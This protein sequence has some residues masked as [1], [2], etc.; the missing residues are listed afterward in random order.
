MSLRD[1]QI[2]AVDAVDRAQLEGTRSLLIVAPTGA[3][4]GHVIAHL[5]RRQRSLVLVHREEIVRDLARRCAPASVRTL[6][7]GD[8]DGPADA[9]VTVAL[10]QSL[11]AADVVIPGLE[12]IITDE[13][14]H[15]VASTYR[16]LY[17]RHPDAIH[18][19]LTATPARSDGVGLGDVYEEIHVAARPSELLERGLL[20]PI[21]V[22]APDSPSD[23]LA[24][25]AAAAY[26]RHADG[27]Q[28]IVF[29]RTV[30]E[31]RALAAEWPAPAAAITGSS[32]GRTESI[33]AFRRGELRALI[34]VYVLTE[35]TDLPE[36]EVCVLARG[37]TSAATYLQIVGRVLRPLPGKRALLIDL[38]GVV[39]THGLPHDDREYSLTGARGVGRA[40]SALAL[41]TCLSCWHVYRGDACPECGTAAPPPPPSRVVQRELRAV[42]Y[43]DPRQHEGLLRALVRRFPNP[44]QARIVFFKKTGR[45]ASKQEMSHAAKPQ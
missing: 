9:Q 15:A 13:A 37:C 44:Q 10:V 18:V 32:R 27:R 16:A 43:V 34:N 23:S 40:T 7:A 25:H 22:L 8:Y 20:A 36:A 24:D 6:I 33:E 12:L 39:H 3:G 1:Y 11:H 14:H 38:R 28:A 30:G 2:R 21:S 4:K 35:G 41:R 19:G 5:A 17:A 45:W 42:S 31:A 29:V 26:Q